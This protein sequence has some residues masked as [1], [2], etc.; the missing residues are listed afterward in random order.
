MTAY[1]T[2]ILFLY[3]HT[4]EYKFCGTD[5]YI[6]GVEIHMEEVS[7]GERLK[8]RMFG[9]F[10]ISY[11]GQSLNGSKTS[12]SR[13]VHLMQLLLHFRKS[14]V[15]RAMVEEALF[16]D[17]DVD[18][19]HHSLRSVIY[20]ARKKLESSGLPKADY[21]VYKDGLLC[22]TDAIPVEEDAEMFENLFVQATRAKNEDERLAK[23][24]DACHCYTG[25]F[26]E[27]YGGILWVAAESR[28]YRGMFCQCVEDV[29]AIL[30]KKQ[31]YM[32]LEQLG[33]YA[34]KVS[35]FSDWETLTM[36]ALVGMGRFE[37]AGRL[38][39]NTVQMY[40]EERDLKP[41]EKMMEVFDQ[42]GSQF[43]YP[44]EPLD[45]IQRKLQDNTRTGPYVCSYPI[46]K[47]I[48]QMLGRL[49]AR[50]GNSI[51]LMLCTIVNSKGN[52]MRG[53]VKLEA[54]S[55]RLEEA[56]KKSLRSNDI[57]NRYGKG[58]FL[59][60]LINISMENCSIVQKRIDEYF[61]TGR[62][63]VGVKYQIN[64]TYQEDLM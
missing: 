15:S 25:E 30:R 60:L 11:K 20:N 3:M 31:D 46:F 18:D 53:S 42:L 52:P 13:F 34:A 12:Q 48:Y 36:E 23:L 32:Q 59:V 2:V 47:G 43:M 9:S 39:T 35:P 7:N 17:R 38:Y 63:R 33:L 51:Y 61:Y 28:R 49:A 4:P 24:L 1:V 8:V 5:F 40:F 22:W 19:I 58:Q 10:G 21:I 6:K 55:A 16:G 45:S 64:T 14:G 62:Q 37:E 56:L 54:M 41:S 44:F 26:L 57:V 50:N 29:A 27:I